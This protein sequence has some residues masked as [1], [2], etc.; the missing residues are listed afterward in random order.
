MSPRRNLEKVFCVR[1]SKKDERY[2]CVIA[3]VGKTLTLT[4][5][6]ELEVPPSLDHSLTHV[7]SLCLRVRAHWSG[8]REREGEQK[9]TE[10]ICSSGRP[11]FVFFAALQDGGL[12]KRSCFS[13]MVSSMVPLAN[14]SWLSHFAF[15]L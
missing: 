1:V 3:F 2:M 7:R 10:E 14:A 4:E 12:L 5:K 13:S 6:K 11:L 15:P 9:A 8:E